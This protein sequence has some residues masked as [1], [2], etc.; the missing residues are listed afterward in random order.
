MRKPRYHPVGAH[1]RVR[2]D[3]PVRPDPLARRDP[4]K[5]AANPSVSIHLSTSPPECPL[6][7]TVQQALGS[8]QTL[9]R[10]LHKLRASMARCRTCS[11]R[12]ACPILDDFNAQLAIALQEIAD[13]WSLT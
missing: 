4:P 11:G 7:A 13:E 6:L 2:P 5:P 3:P 9:K 12:E 10:A 8:A 1:P